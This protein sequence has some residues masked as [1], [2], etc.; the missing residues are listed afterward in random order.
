[1]GPGEIDES[2]NEALRRHESRLFEKYV[3]D[4]EVS[5]VSPGDTWRYFKG[6][7]EPPENWAELCFEDGLWS[8]G[9]SNIGYD[10]ATILTDMRRPGDE[11]G[12][13]SVYVRKNFTITELTSLTNLFLEIEYDDGFIAYLNGQEVAGAKPMLRKPLTPRYEASQHC[14]SG[15][16]C[17]ESIR[18]DSLRQYLGNSG[19]ITSPQ[20]MQLTLLHWDCLPKGLS[21]GPSRGRD[22]GR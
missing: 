18:R 2:T 1:M 9:A 14:K 5:L 19:R 16:T 10:D 22:V 8:T 7:S 3:P 20:T 21:I 4:S 13:L 11:D 12:Y 17:V 15:S 6:R